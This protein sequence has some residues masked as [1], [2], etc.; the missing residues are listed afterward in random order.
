M[1]K[2]FPLDLHSGND[3]TVADEMA[4]ISNA[5][6]GAEAVQIR[7]F[8]LDVDPRDGIQS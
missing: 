8:L 1:L 2:T 3:E 7:L 4:R 6:V 5:L